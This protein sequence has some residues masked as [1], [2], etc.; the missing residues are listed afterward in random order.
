LT[1]LKNIVAGMQRNLHRILVVSFLV[2]FFL[3]LRFTAAIACVLLPLP[4]VLDAYERADVVITARVVSIEKTKE[5]DPFHLDIRSAT[6]VVQKVFKGNVEVHD[7]ISFAQ[8]NGID[9]L[10]TFDEKMIGREYLLYLNPPEEASGLWYLGQGR[11]SEV[12]DAANDLLYLNNVDKVQGKTRVS[13]TL[14]DDFPVAGKNVRI[15][16][17]NKT[18]QIAA[19]EHGVYEVYGLPPGN[20]LIAPEMPYGWIIDRDESFPTVS[21]RR[22]HSKSYKA[23]TL[24]P[25]RHAV[26][27][28][29]FKIDNAIEGHVYDLNGRPLVDANIAL[30]PEDD[31]GESSQFTDKKGRFKFES[32]SAGKYNL[33][34]YEDRPGSEQLTRVS[35]YDP[36]KSKL[37]AVLP[38]NIRHGES[39]RGLKIFVSTMASKPDRHKSPHIKRERAASAERLSEYRQK[40]R[41]KFVTTE[42]RQTLQ[43]AVSSL[44]LVS[45]AGLEP[46]TR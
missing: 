40:Q 25:K 10:W 5:P 22:L 18:L 34:V 29:A 33:I 15:I 6:M 1:E 26:I 41:H 23:F 38:I 20:Y 11:S 30:M 13:G 45:R 32:V 17:K 31:V 36:Q 37:M 24:R 27:D 9:C 2:V 12:S 39:R 46:A 28:F 21:E 35:S 8:G 3:G 42:K 7:A 16:G 4:T 43:P 14:H 44:I 19:D